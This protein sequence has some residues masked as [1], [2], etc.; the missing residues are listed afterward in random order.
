MLLSE[1]VSHMQII[2]P[3]LKN[4][5]NLELSIFIS[6]IQNPQGNSSPP[7]PP[8]LYYIQKLGIAILS[9]EGVEC[10]W[11][12]SGDCGTAWGFDG[13]IVT[14]EM[15]QLFATT[16]SSGL[17]LLVDLRSPPWSSSPPQ[18]SDPDSALLHSAKSTLDGRDTRVV[19]ASSQFTQ[20]SLL[21][22]RLEPGSSS[23][24][25]LRADGSRNTGW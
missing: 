24:K 14:V 21:L 25:P 12:D 15:G 16:S 8:I 7:L 5:N 22:V 23:R 20:E 6:H 19:A 9:Q 10:L 4:V 13:L 11:Q 1:T 2:K 3:L 18:S 17:K